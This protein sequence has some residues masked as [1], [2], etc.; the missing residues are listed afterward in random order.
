MTL[1]LEKALDLALSR[2]AGL[3]ATLGDAAFEVG[4]C[5][6]ELTM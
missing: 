1:S 6:L 4:C 2:E 3:R 5:T